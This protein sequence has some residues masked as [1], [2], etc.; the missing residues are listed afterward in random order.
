MKEY[1]ACSWRLGGTRAHDFC[2]IKRHLQTNSLN[3]AINNAP[4]TRKAFR[5]GEGDRTSLH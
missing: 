1:N 2:I 3:L 5:V 4:L